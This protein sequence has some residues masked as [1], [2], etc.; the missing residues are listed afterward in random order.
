MV[1]IKYKGKLSCG[2]CGNIQQ[3]SI[4]KTSGGKRSTVVDQVICNKCGRHISHDNKA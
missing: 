4:G 1:D 2:F 3:V